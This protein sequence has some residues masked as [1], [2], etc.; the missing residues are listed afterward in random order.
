VL[1]ESLA[2]IVR[3]C[4]RPPHPLFKNVDDRAKLWI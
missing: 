2:D 1:P 3:G 4:K